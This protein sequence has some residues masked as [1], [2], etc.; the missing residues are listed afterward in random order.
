MNK[1]Q[2]TN[3]KPNL[4]KSYQF[5]RGLD[6][7]AQHSL[8]RIGIASKALD[9]NPPIVVETGEAKVNNNSRK[10][11]LQMYGESLNTLNVGDIE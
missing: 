11:G 3:E 10:Y 4:I 6:E 8:E 1:E 2:L 9:S 7:L 5:S